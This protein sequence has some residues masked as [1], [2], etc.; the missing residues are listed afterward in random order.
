MK[1]NR[2]IVRAWTDPAFRANLSAEDRAKIPANP[3]GDDLDR[4]LENVVGGFTF[5]DGCGTSGCTVFICTDPCGTYGASCNTNVTTC[6][7]TTRVGD[8]DCGGGALSADAGMCHP[9]ENPQ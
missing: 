8:P 3:A 7:K 1:K 5:G 4:D 2:K 9:I 6:P